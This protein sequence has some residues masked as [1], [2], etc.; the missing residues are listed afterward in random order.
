MDGT[1]S[2]KQVKMGNKDRS[3]PKTVGRPEDFTG[4]ETAIVYNE[5]LQKYYIIANNQLIE[6]DP[7]TFRK[8]VVSDD[9]SAVSV[10]PNGNVIFSSQEEDMEK[11]QV[12][13]QIFNSKICQEI[14]PIED[15]DTMFV[16]VL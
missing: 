1:A 5:P 3:T 15:E 16:Y 4:E 9:V 11:S 2:S 7:I 10:D 12:S 6:Y 14:W 13:L 8:R